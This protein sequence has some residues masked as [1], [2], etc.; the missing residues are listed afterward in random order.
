LSNFSQ[1][2]PE[3]EKD[4][5]DWLKYS[6]ISS[7]IK[8]TYD[9]QRIL[10]KFINEVIHFFDENVQEIK[11]NTIQN[12]GALVDKDRAGYTKANEVFVKH[13]I[14]LLRPICWFEQHFDPVMGT[15]FEEMYFDKD[16]GYSTFEKD[17]MDFLVIRFE[18]LAKIGPKVIGD[19][20][21][22]KDFIVKKD[23]ISKEKEVGAIISNSITHLNFSRAF[24]D[25][26]YKN[27]YCSKFYTEKHIDD[28]KKRY[29][30]R[31]SP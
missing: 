23:N 12:L 27:S 15:H 11:G 24:L 29:E 25:K 6:Q 2:Y 26:I 10:I 21:D 9:K 28:F 4:I 19:F 31:V 16:L 1:N 7:A 14:M 13:S 20:L 5:E 17:G 18:D 8:E 3:Y 30:D 22:I